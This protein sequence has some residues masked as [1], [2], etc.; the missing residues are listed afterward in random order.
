[1]IIIIIIIIITNIIIIIVTNEWRHDDNTHIAGITLHG[2]IQKHQTKY[3]IRL[4][5]EISNCTVSIIGV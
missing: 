2:R 1:M 5:A 3:K 4:Q